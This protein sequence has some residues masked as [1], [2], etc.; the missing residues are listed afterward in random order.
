[1]WE[2]QQ[3]PTPALHSQSKNNAKD[4]FLALEH[5]TIQHRT[6]EHRKISHST[7]HKKTAHHN[8][9][10]ITDQNGANVHENG[11]QQN[12]ARNSGL[13][14]AKSRPYFRN[15]RQKQI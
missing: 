1:M 13:P 9:K 10:N 2:G 8:S 14:M 15:G 7:M 6:K 3:C 11:M 5:G 12:R 4:E